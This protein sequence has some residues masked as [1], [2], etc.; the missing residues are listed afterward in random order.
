[1]VGI[2]GTD[3]LAEGMRRFRRVPLMMSIGEM[4]ELPEIPWR[5]AER[6]E[7]LRVQTR[8][9]MHAIADLLP[10]AYHGLYTRRSR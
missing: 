1:P 6:K 3:I 5:S 4:I 8:R 10:P 7:I 9:I 2:A